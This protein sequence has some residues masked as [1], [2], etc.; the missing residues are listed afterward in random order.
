VN[1]D[2]LTPAGAILDLFRSGTRAEQHCCGARVI[3]QAAFARSLLFVGLAVA[4]ALNS[5][6]SP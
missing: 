2:A 3:N 1:V 4:I 5:L 6:S